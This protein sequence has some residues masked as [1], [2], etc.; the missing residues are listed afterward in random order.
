MASKLLFQYHFL[1]NVKYE[2][3]HSEFLVGFKAEKLADQVHVVSQVSLVNIAEA[4]C[5]E[6]NEGS[7]LEPEE[8]PDPEPDAFRFGLMNS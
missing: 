2:S 5:V 1:G 8:V 3:S 7:V 6:E 4:F